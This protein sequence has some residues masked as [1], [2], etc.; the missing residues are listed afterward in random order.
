MTL[1]PCEHCWKMFP[2]TQIRK[3][4]MR[5]GY[6]Y[7]CYDEIV[8]R[9][10]SAWLQPNIPEPS[11]VPP[12]PVSAPWSSPPPERP[13]GHRTASLVKTEGDYAD[14]AAWEAW[15]LDTD[16]ADLLEPFDTLARAVLYGLCA[17]L[18]DHKASSRQETTP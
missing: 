2:T 5:A 1:E 13:W 3:H 8:I 12:A 18:W 16:H 14:F 7:L 6:C 9:P 4:G 10:Q 17:R 11:T 15:M